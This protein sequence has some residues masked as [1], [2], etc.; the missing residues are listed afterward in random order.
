MSTLRSTL[1]GAEALAALALP[2][3]GIATSSTPQ[4]PLDTVCGA[5]PEGLSLLV[6]HT[7]GVVATNSAGAE[8]LD[9]PIAA[10]PNLAVR[11]PDG[12]VWVEAAPGGRFGVDRIPPSGPAALVVEGEVA[13]TGVGWLGGRSAAAVIDANGTATPDQPDGFGTVTAAFADGSRTDVSEAAGWEWGVNSATIGA[14]RL[15]ERGTSEGY[16]WFAAYGPGGEPLDDWSLPNEEQPDQPPDRWWPVPAIAGDGSQPVLSWIEPMTP[17]S[18]QLVVIDPLTGAETMRVDLGEIGEVP[19][20]AD[21]DGR[22]WVGTFADTQDAETGE[23]QPARI[24]AVDTSSATPAPVDVACPPGATGT[25]D[26]LGVPVPVTPPTTPPPTTTAPATTQP[27][28]AGQCGEYVFTD[29]AYPIRKCE[30]GW[31]VMLTQRML[32]ERGYDIE[33][34]GF[35]GPATEQAVRSFQGDAGLAVD[36]LVGPNTWAALYTDQPG[37][38]DGDGSGTIDP[39]EVPA[40]CIEEGNEVVCAGESTD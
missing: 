1:L 37:A 16:E 2:A 4:P 5:V 14:D 36:G 17:T 15:L 8:L 12:T 40:D 22:F 11:G 24:V 18:W 38:F 9:A 26:R 7:G 27:A 33:A 39:W 29:F 34:D 32:V 21:F 6:P 20:H 35:F 30:Q 19:V 3:T 25:I 13:L 23:W 10:G 31:D 28:T